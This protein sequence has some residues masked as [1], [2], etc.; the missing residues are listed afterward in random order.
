MDDF[1]ENWGWNRAT[2]EAK[3]WPKKE[4][5]DTLTKNL[6][7]MC[8]GLTTTPL[9]VADDRDDSSKHVKSF[10]KAIYNKIC[11]RSNAESKKL[12]TRAGNKIIVNKYC[13]T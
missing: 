9:T 7:R 1:T 12:Q 3:M 8:P 4:D 2:H 10:G 13:S 6:E 5:A 11:N